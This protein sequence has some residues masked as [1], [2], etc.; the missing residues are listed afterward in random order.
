MMMTLTGGVLHHITSHITTTASMSAAAG[1]VVLTLRHT[2]PSSG[3][4][5]MPSNQPQEARYWHQQVI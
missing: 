5:S 1:G 3:V 4:T 2:L